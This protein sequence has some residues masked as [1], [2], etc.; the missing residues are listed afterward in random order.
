M[1]RNYA[2]LILI[3]G[4]LFEFFDFWFLMWENFLDLIFDRLLL[5]MGGSLGFLRVSRFSWESFLD[6]VGS[7]T[8]M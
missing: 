6:F 8:S 1:I 2:F 3:F 7:E 5:L 4:N